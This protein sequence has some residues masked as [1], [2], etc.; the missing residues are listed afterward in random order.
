MDVRRLYSAAQTRE[1]E[2]RAVQSLRIPGYRLMQRAAA[3]AW[4]E[5][6]AA[7]PLAKSVDVVCGS[8]NNG[9]DGYEIARLAKA[10]RWR[11]RVWQ[12]GPAPA[13]GEGAV[14]V[15]AWKKSGGRAES[16]PLPAMFE[17]AAVVDALVGIGLSRPLE[18]AVLAAVAAINRSSGFKLSVDVPSGLNADTGVVLGDAVV[19]QMTVSFIA[20][21]AGLYTGEGPQNCGVLRL[22]SLQIPAAAYTGISPTASLLDERVLTD[23]LGL[24]RRSRTAHKGDHGHVLVIGGDH[25]MM[26]AALLAAR[27]ALRGGAGWVTVASRQAHAAAM[28]AAQPEL[29]CRGI[30]DTRDVAPLMERADV[31]ALGPGLGQTNWGRALFSQAVSAKKLL[32]VD[33]DGLNW[34]AQNPLQREDWVLTPHPGEAARLLGWSTREVQADRYA[35]AHELRQ[36]YGGVVVLKGAGTVIAGDT[37]SV[38]PYGNP[39][40]AVGGSGDV[41]TGVIAALL[42]QGLPPVAAAQAGVVAHAR[43]GDVAAK[44]GERGL[45]PSDLLDPLRAQLNPC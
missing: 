23:G 12:V 44:N 18:G 20:S 7:C 37:L 6:R 14:A 26:G 15:K 24:P 2:K 30:E 42:A 5:L 19:A 45:L 40:M 39:G 36:R 32:V 43:A 35:A 29:M 34:L 25:G 21:K 16:G 8:G 17:G 1:I 41:L 10:A 13:K 38:C 27:A 22:Q 33:A 11:V 9:G 4:R 28:T 31:I 3:A